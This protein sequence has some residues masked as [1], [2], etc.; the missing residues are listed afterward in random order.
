MKKISI[1]SLHLG[2][3]GIEKSVVNLANILSEEYEVEIISTYKLYNDCPFKINDNVKVK[4]LITKYKPNR[5]EWKNALKKFRLFKLIK[6]TYISLVVLF[7]RRSKTINAIKESNSDVI[8]STRI[9]FNNW[10]GKYKQGKTY[11]IGWEHNHHHGDVKYINSLVKS[12]RNLDSLVLVSDSLRNFYKKELKN[13]NYKC[14]CV[15]IPNSLDN[16]PESVSDLKGNRLVS[17]GRMSREK[18]FPDLIDVFKR[19]HDKNNDLVLDIV[20]DGA[21]KNMVIDKIYDYDLMDSV[22]FH[23]YQNKEYID[24]LLHEASLYLMSS[25][26][27]SFGIVLIEAMS[28][29]IPCLA[30]TSAEG[31]NDIIENGENGYLI[32]ERDKD[33][34]AN[35]I[36]EVMGDIELRKRLGEK[37]R[38][39]SLKYTKDI[40]KK[41]WLLLLKKR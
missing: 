28:H 1:L 10:L 27:E 9:L 31:A 5:E 22:N 16:V 23:G 18:A 36:I 29:G 25:Y 19:A 12:C 24:K 14:K 2:Y 20:G 26:T 4:Y 30:F 39:D 41:E 37:A 33:K 34:M 8:I 40:V 15:F 11:K 21:Q 38:V 13:K 35:K 7:L 6:E 32:S 3:G 17:V